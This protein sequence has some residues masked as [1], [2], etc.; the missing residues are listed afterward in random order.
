MVRQHDKTSMVC[1]LYDRTGT[2]YLHIVLT[3]TPCSSE[4]KADWLVV[5]GV[6][7]PWIVFLPRKCA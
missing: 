7:E 1:Q 4:A 5:V 6:F 3:A 2:S